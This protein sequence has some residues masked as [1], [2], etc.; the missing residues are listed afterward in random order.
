MT[1]KKQTI[2]IRLSGMRIAGCTPLKG[3]PGSVSWWLCSFQIAI[4]IRLV[5]DPVTVPLD[6]IR[7]R[8]T[9]FLQPEAAAGPRGHYQQSL[10]RH[11]RNR[12]SP[13]GTTNQRSAFSPHKRESFYMFE[14]FRG[15]SVY[16]S[17]KGNG[18]QA[19]DLRA[20]NRSQPG[21]SLDLKMWK[22][23]NEIAHRVWNV[24]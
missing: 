1:G 11:Q 15:L 8:P 4:C 20:C 23:E 2:L 12:Y 18:E 17:S 14:K 13:A 9:I 22:Y 16:V 21:T 7:N 10:Q 3:I 19:M 24:T 5:A 6:C